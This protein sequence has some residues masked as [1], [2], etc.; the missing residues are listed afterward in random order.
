MKNF[1]LKIFLL[2]GLTVLPIITINFIIDPLQCFRVAKWYKPLFDSNERMQSAC[3]ARSYNYNSIILGASH[4]QNFDPVYLDQIFGFSTLKLTLA[5]STF[6]EQNQLLD[7]A[8]KTGK[9]QNVVWG[10]DTNILNDDPKRTRG[11]VMAFPEHVFRPNLINNIKFL[12][13]PYLIKHYFKMAAHYFLGVY[14]EYT[15]LRYL[16]NWEKSFTFSKERVLLYFDA[17][18]KGKFEAME[19]TNTKLASIVPDDASKENINENI[20]KI[21]KNN[22][23]VHFKIFFPPYTTLRFVDLFVTNRPMLEMELD[24]KGYLIEN[25]VSLENVEVFDF[26]DVREITQN[27]DNYKDLSHFSG[28]VNKYILDSLK[29][30]R[31][32]IR[33]GEERDSSK[34]LRAQ[35][36][37][38]DFTDLESKK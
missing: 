13:D 3:L 34:R 35:I 7:L 24:L 36:E 32:R 18:K 28:T 27:L 15:D 37:N 25:L 16:N 2:A 10:V 21:I 6:Y 4:V 22:P 19:N 29:S 17:V 26:Q 38:F 31:H 1:I 9:V 20:L 30:G 33:Q 23:Q 11:D 8:I 5:G 12:L 14:S